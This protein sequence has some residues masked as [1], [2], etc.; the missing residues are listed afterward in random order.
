MKELLGINQSLK[1]TLHDGASYKTGELNEMTE[2]QLTQLLENYEQIEQSAALPLPVTILNVV[3]RIISYIAF[4]FTGING[5]QLI[6]AK[7]DHEVLNPR[8]I[9][10]FVITCCILLIS[11]GIRLL[12]EKMYAKKMEK[13]I[14]SD[15]ALS[16]A[17]HLESATDFAK[18]QL[19]IPEN[20]DE[21]DVFLY[22]YKEAPGGA[23]TVETNSNLC[24]Y[25]LLT[26]FVFGEKGKLVLASADARYDIPWE[27]IRSL[28]VVNK[29]QS[30]YGWN[31]ETLFNEGEF[32][33]YKMWSDN[34]GRIWMRQYC[35]LCFMLKGE[36]FTFRFPIYE[37]NVVE[38][39]LPES[40]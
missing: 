3:I 13:V 29:N 38:K 36:E 6:R 5:V 21:I 34:M 9:K 19:G 14:E 35:E 16:A 12:I 1:A 37:K 28:R 11:S 25:T 2:Q 15:T 7:L 33:Q 24:H 31:K 23:N 40:L 27:D 20:A 18:S 26:M 17:A 22:L 10:L 39:Y 4:L 8:M 30:I 32:K